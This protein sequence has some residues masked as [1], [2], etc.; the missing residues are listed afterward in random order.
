MSILLTGI[1]VFCARI[2]DVSIGTLRTIS[3][4]R[5]KTKIAFV[6]GFF[7]I[8]MWLLVLSTVLDKVMNYPIIALF[9]AFGFST[10]NVVGI[11]I[12]KRLAMGQIVMRIITSQHGELLASEIRQEGFP[13]TTVDGEGA[14]GNVLILF[15]ACERKNLKRIIP[16]IEKHTP[17]AFYVIEHAGSISKVYNPSN[18]PRTGWRAIL[19]KK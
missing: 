11:L 6:L 5:G 10:G 1:L 16:I 18:V 8:S 19:K 2:I 13:V 14:K 7:E 9:Y 12:E 4:I 15:I 3:I 17:E